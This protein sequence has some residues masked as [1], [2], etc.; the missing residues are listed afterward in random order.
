[1]I[2]L[3]LKVPF[4]FGDDPDLEGFQY[5]G[6]NHDGQDIYAG[7]SGSDLF[8][9][10]VP[11]DMVGLPVFS[12]SRRRI[13]DSRDKSIVGGVDVQLS[14][15]VTV[16]LDTDAKSVQRLVGA[17]VLAQTPLVHAL[18]SL[19]FNRAQAADDE[20][21]MAALSEAHG[22]FSV[23]WIDADNKTF[24]MGFNELGIIS[25]A[26]AEH[27]KSQVFAAFAEKSQLAETVFDS[28]SADKGLAAMVAGSGSAVESDV[29][30][31]SSGD[32][33]SNESADEGANA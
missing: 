8:V 12:Q 26:L 29:V 31:E 28:L 13:N 2:I 4:L 1:M 33:T 15:D 32:A 9:D 19:E 17:L 14:E 16:R 11:A 10:A 22:K 18:F 23:D 24:K 27:E 6:R 3:K 25:Q 20:E 7:E 21:T 30:A 5:L